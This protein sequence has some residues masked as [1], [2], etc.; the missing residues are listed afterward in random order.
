MDFTEP[1]PLEILNKEAAAKIYARLPKHH[2]SLIILYSGEP[3]DPIKCSLRYHKLDAAPEYEALSYVWGS[4]E[5]PKLIELKRNSCWITRN[6]DEALH[7]LR[8]LTENRV[9]WIDALAINQ[10]DIDE[11]NHQVR[12]MGDIYSNWRGL[13][14][15]SVMSMKIAM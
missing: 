15:G 13:L 10:T 8:S 6:L 4:H 7:R 5:D 14:F 9:L 12:I 3:D 2:I 1:V 11:R